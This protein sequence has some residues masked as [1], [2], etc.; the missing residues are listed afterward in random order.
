MPF[1]QLD[2]DPYL[3]LIDDRF[4]WII[5]GYTT[6]DRYLSQPLILSPNADEFLGSSGELQNIALSNANYIRDAA[7]VV[8]DAYDGTLTVYAIDETDPVLA[9]YE[10]IFPTLFTPL[11]EASEELRAHFRYPLNLFQIQA[12]MYRAYHMEDI[13]VFYNQED[14]WQLPRRSATT[15]IPNRCSPTT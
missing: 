8:I 15:T 7:K 12:Q 2:S 1:L 3:A 9:T 4:Q 10:K 11:S 13:E 14:L 6:S 5:D